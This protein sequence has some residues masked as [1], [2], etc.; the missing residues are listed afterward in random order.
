MVDW[1]GLPNR[2]WPYCKLRQIIRPRN[3]NLI[4]GAK[5]NIKIREMGLSNNNCNPVIGNTMESIQSV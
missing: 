1:T 3:F 5:R 4:Y 2:V